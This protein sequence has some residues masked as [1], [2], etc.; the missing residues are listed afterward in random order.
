MVSQWSVPLQVPQLMVPLQP[1]GAVL[2]FWPI[3]QAV[4][5][6]QL[7]SPHE[8]DVEHVWLPGAFGHIRIS[9]G[10]QGPSPM[11]APKGPKVPVA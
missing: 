3:G 2:Q 8:Q 4:L 7:Q 11:Q 9:P 1:S 6:V 10:L 5:G